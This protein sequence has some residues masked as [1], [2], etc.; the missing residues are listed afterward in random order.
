M[1]TDSELFVN[2]QG[3]GIGLSQEVSD[4]LR[5]VAEAQRAL[6]RLA[7]LGV[8]ATMTPGVSSLLLLQEAQESLRRANQELGERVQERTAQ[9][10]EAHQQ[11]VEEIERR[12]CVEDERERLLE[13]NRR[14]RA[15]LEAVLKQMPS[16]VVVA[17]APTGRLILGN[18]RVEQIWKRPFV[19]CATIPDYSQYQGFYPDGT[20]YR[21]EDWPLARSLTDG[22]RVQDERIEFLRGDDTRGILSVSSAPVYNYAGG[23]AAAVAVFADVTERVRAEEALRESEERL[24]AELAGVQQLQRISTQLVQ[25]DSIDAL[26]QAVLEAAMVLAGSDM[27]TFQMLRP[28]TGELELLACKGLHPAS[29]T[30]WERVAAESECVYGTALREGRRVVVEDVETS[31]ITA[32]SPDLPYFRLSGIRGVQSTPLVSRDGHLVGMIAT[33]WR[34]PHRPAERELHLMDVLARQAA[35]LIQQKQTQERLEEARA[36]AEALAGKAVRQAAE[37]DA[38]ISAIAD[39]LMV[40]DGEGIL[41]RMS[42]AAEEILGAP[43]E[44]LQQPL[45]D[46]VSLLGVARP[47]GTLLPVEETATARALRGETVPSQ[48]MAVHRP[49]GCTRWIVSSTA[50]I[51]VGGEVTGAVASFKDV[52]ALREAQEAAERRA[53][54]VDAVLDAIGDAVALFDTRGHI[55]R[56]NLAGERIWGYSQEQRGQTLSETA[57]FAGAVQEDGTPWEADRLPLVRALAGETVQSAVIGYHW[58]NKGFRWVSAS[59]APVRLADGTL[60]GAVGTFPDITETKETQARLQRA[61]EELK[62]NAEELARRAERLSAQR[63]WM[64]RLSQDLLSE[65]ARLKAMI[66]HVPVGILVASPEGRLQLTNPAADQI[67]GVPVWGSDGGLD[68]PG[69]ELRRPDDTPWPKDEL[70]WKRAALHQEWVQGAEMT[71]VR[72]DGSCRHLT[73]NVAPILDPARKSLGTV[74][75]LQDITVLKEAERERQRLE[76]MKTEFMANVSHELRT[77]LSSVLGYAELL[78]A[79][80]GLGE[81]QRE[82]VE[83]IYGSGLRLEQLINEL[84]DISRLE[85]AE[86]QLDIGPVAI[87]YVIESCLDQ[88]GPKA[89]ERGLTI[90]AEVPSELPSVEGDAD[91]LEQVLGNLLSNAIKFTPSGGTITVRVAVED[92]SLILEVSDTGVGVAKDELPHLFTRFTRGSNAQGVEGTGLGLYIVRNIVVAHGGCVEAESELGQGST[93]RVRLPLCHS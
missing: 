47:D 32:S 64:V 34:E 14:Q 27:G 28:E 18:P 70:P 80:E 48:L 21:P 65:R 58:P 88:A 44:F 41:R 38:I 45:G 83:S 85:S 11:L 93:F 74:V 61:N 84:L 67:L 76:E 91:R 33:H 92:E 31:P 1:S 22:E 19:R 71:A 57:L 20:P 16:G 7:A 78:Q 55:L 5:Q 59:A 82:F 4:L 66:E 39:G 79:D 63:D 30:H 90:V 54:E 40:Y 50:P 72:A 13:E 15:F 81:L 17:E 23:I 73:V 69:L 24:A 25:E 26:Y 37:L 53:A 56:M 35:D 6:E 3:G 52:T 75:A 62:A 8:D 36:Q 42:P 89:I 43:L 68:H 77:P 49:D 86:F 2:D 9:L 10:E 29:V 46:R 87:G 60:I 51:V 12:R